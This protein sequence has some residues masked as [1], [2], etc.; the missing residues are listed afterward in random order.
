MMTHTGAKPYSCDQCTKSFRLS[1][2]L[3]NPNCNVY[4]NIYIYITYGKFKSYT[5]IVLIHTPSLFKKKW[6]IVT[7]VLFKM[8][9]KTAKQ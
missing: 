9:I 8:Q 3:N 4:S 6:R 5:L 7:K 1:Y 2:A